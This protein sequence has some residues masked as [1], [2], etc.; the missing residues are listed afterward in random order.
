M[1]NL[2][3]QEQTFLQVVQEWMGDENS[4]TYLAGCTRGQLQIDEQA[5]TIEAS[6]DTSMSPALVKALVNDLGIQDI[7]VKPMATMDLIHT[8]TQ[9]PITDALRDAANDSASENDSDR[10]TGPGL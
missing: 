3:P 10:L 9:T 4:E 1:E 8:V 5:G 2:T 7:R 6:D